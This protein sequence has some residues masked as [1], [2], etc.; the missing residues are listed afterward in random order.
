MQK[1]RVGVTA[2]SRQIVGRQATESLQFATEMAAPHELRTPMG[3]WG[4]GP[5]QSAD[6]SMATMARESTGRNQSESGRNQEERQMAGVKRNQGRRALAARMRRCLM[7]RQGAS[8]LRPRPPFPFSGF[9]GSEGICQGFASRAQKQGAP[10]TDFL[11]SERVTEIRERGPLQSGPWRLPLVAPGDSLT[12]RQNRA[13]GAAVS[14]RSA[15][16]KWPAA[17][18]S[19][20]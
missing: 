11:A 16:P 2:R 3:T 18:R 6:G 10:L 14:K 13:D 9:Y 17:A 12:S 4:E 1:R 15:L 8:P 7:L 5:N 20:Y 19:F